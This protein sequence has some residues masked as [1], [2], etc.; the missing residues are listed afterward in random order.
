MFTGVAVLQLVA[1][2][3]VALNDPI[4]KYLTD[5]PNTDV[6]TKVTVRHLLTLPGRH[7]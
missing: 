5:Y 3:K 2:N 7:R 6:A 4:G 1:A